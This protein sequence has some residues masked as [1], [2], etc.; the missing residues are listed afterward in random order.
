MIRL[1]APGEWDRVREIRLRALADTPDAFGSTYGD[2]VRNGETEW[3]AWVTGWEG[4]RN[5]MV[6]AEAEDAWVGMAV[7]SRSGEGSDAHMYA[8][9]VDPAQRRRGVGARLVE[10]VLSWA[11]TWE[12][13]A[14]VLGVTQRNDAE[15]FYERLGFEDTVSATRFGRGAP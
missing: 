7:G 8:M 2:E 6:V 14:V 1:V 13:R 15:R 12:A 10:E 11:R 4:T 5:A 9:W 3:R